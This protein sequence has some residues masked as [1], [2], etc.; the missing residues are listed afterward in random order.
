[1]ILDCIWT[2]TRLDVIV[3]SIPQRDR[4][5]VCVTSRSCEK[6][7][8]EYGCAIWSGGPTSKLLN[9]QRTFFQR[10]HISLPPLQKRFDYFTLML[11]F[12]IRMREAPKYLHNILP[13]LTSRS[14]HNFRKSSYPV[15]TVSRTSTLTSFLP[16][17]IVLWNGLP[18]DLQLLTTSNSFKSA[19]K[20]YQN[21]PNSISFSCATRSWC[22][23]TLMILLS[24]LY[25]PPLQERSL[26]STVYFSTILFK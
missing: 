7:D 8:L 9:L 1:M 10:H 24:V 4:K 18:T 23:H 22:Y 13:D 16:R 2:L 25:T 26:I 12:K 5:F 3:K 6:T 19:L 21:L 15:P 11:F 17:A 20:K 14:G